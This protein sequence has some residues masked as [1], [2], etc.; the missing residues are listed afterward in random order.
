M[1]AKFEAQQRSQQESNKRYNKLASGY[2]NSSR[3]GG[4]D[5]DKEPGDQGGMSHIFIITIIES[6]TS[7]VVYICGTTLDSVSLSLTVNCI[8]PSLT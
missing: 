3:R 8:P 1:N 4:G 5:N 7:A 6:Y 2:R